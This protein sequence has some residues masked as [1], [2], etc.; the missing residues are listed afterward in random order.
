M[1]SWK[2]VLHESSPA[3]DFPSGMA[4]SNLGGGSGTAFLRQDGQWATPSTG[5]WTLAAGNTNNVASGKTVSFS[6]GSNMSISQAYSSGNHTI[7][8]SATNTTYS[9]GD[10]GLTQKN[11]TTTL[12]NK[13][14]ALPS[15]ADN[16]GSWTLNAGSATGISSG[17]AVTFAVST[18]LAIVQ[19]GTGNRTVT[20]K[21]A[22][23]GVSGSQLAS[24]AIDHP[25]KFASGVVDSTAIS[26]SAVRASELA[27]SGNGS[28]TQF[29][30]AD[31]DGTFTWAVPAGTTYTSG[32]GIDIS[33]TEIAVAEDS[34]NDDMIEAGAI[35]DGHLNSTNSATSGY[36]L[37]KSP[38]SSKFTWKP[39]RVN[40][41]WGCR[42]YMKYG[43]YYYPGSTYGTND[44]NWSLVSSSAKTT[45]LA[46]HVP[47]FVAPFDFTV[48]ECWIAGH[49]SNN[50]TLQLVLKKGTPAS[51]N[52]T[53]SSTT[54]TNVT[55]GGTT[56]SSAAWTALRRSQRGNFSMSV[57]VSKGD[58]LV[59]QLRKSTNTSSSTTRYFYGVF[60]ITGEI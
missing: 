31:G 44:P 49:V 33:G 5:S 55:G 2:K 54:I 3:G 37:T 27:V 59:P 12:K 9:V 17:Q 48:T 53:S 47:P 39:R 58:I 11:F 50:E 24:G 23:S 41:Q 51:W 30:R 7:T 29:L 4:L 19:G 25:S 34:V 32:A 8:F 46:Y 1:A 43:W 40:W 16:Y 57:S 60:N 10:G 35:G 28:T 45:W 52:N 56:L 6:A 21:I 42:W 22:N 26:S 18:G 38:S 14:D 15:S 36:A 20:M 13:L